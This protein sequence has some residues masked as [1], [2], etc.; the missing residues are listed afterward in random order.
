MLER[1]EDY[2][3][4][5]VRTIKQES[6]QRMILH[7]T[8]GMSG[9][10][11]E[12]L[13]IAG[14][15]ME[16]RNFE[17]GDCFW[18]AANMCQLFGMRFEQV[19]A[20]AQLRDRS[21]LSQYDFLYLPSDIRAIIWSAKLTDIVKKEFFYGKAYVI[22]EMSTILKNYIVA[23]VDLAFQYSIDVFSICRNNIAKLEIRYPGLTFN[24]DQAINRNYE[25]E[26]EAINNPID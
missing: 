25:A 24:A 13:E 22:P 17:L 26:S 11:G 10:I 1:I 5:A 2:Q 21:V 14:M 18:Y 7:C 4:F 19:V 3:E 23:I 16:K 12:F 15:D 20:E 8:M 9:E 6:M